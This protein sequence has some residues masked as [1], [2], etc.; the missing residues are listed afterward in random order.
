MTLASVTVW[1][2]VDRGTTENGCMRI[3]PGT[4]RS[5]LFEHEHS[6][7]DGLALNQQLCAGSFDAGSAVDIELEPG[8]FS[9]HDAM[10]AHGSAPDTSGLRRCGYAVRYMPATSHFDRTIPPT[11]LAQNQVID[12]SK[13]PIWLVRGKDQA[14]NDFSVGR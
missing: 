8:A 13:R 3:V 12:F 2:A 11:R 5:G 7:A 9:F 1:I 14:N 6:V 4:H 10:V